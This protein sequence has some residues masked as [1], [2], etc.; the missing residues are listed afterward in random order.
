VT[1]LSRFLDILSAIPRRLDIA[2]RA[3]LAARAVAALRTRGV[4]RCTMS[5]L[6]AALG[7]KRP[8]LYFYFRDL[9][10]VLEVALEDAQRRYVEFVAK[11][12]EGIDHPIDQL[13]AIARATAEFQAGQRDLIVLLFQLWAAGGSDPEKVIAKNREMLDPLRAGLVARVAEGVTRGQVTPCDAAR[14]V[15]LVLA[16][17]DG[18][19]V[20]QV[21]RRAPPGPVV[22]E[23]IARVLEPLRIRKR[24]ST[25][26]RRPA[27]VD[28]APRR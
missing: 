3:E 15:D 16:T 19:M 2:R 22:E 6:A 24:R 5:D 8:T 1:S 21:T 20:A 27:A 9:G 17:F 10:G 11:R 14:V 25:D 4:H 12:S 26:D 28:R 23:M 13:A 18:A 7:L